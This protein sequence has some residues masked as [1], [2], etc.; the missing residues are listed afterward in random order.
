MKLWG[1][2]ISYIIDGQSV[3]PPSDL[4]IPPDALEI[5]LDSFSGP[6]DLLLYLIRRDD[7]DIMNIPMVHITEQ[8]MEYILHLERSRMDLAVDYLVMAAMLMEIKSRMLLPK[9][10]VENEVEEDPRLLLVRRLQV[11]EQF[12]KAAIQLD[13]LP[14]RERDTFRVIIH[15]P[16]LPLKPALTDITLSQLL[17]AMKAVNLRQTHIINHQVKREVLSV[18]DRMVYVL[19]RLEAEG[20]IPLTSLFKRDEG[21]MGLIVALLA[22]LELAKQFMLLVSQSGDFMPIIIELCRNNSDKLEQ[23]KSQS[24]SSPI[25][26]TANNYG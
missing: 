22:I 4:F 21:R 10:V 3:L 19:E 26:E 23:L 7:I 5:L 17:S 8:Y 6:L 11:Y 9:T 20:I 13:L 14:R 24:G 15:N 1:L 25:E 12:K 16:H 2:I 18:R